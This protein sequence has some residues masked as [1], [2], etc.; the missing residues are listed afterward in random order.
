MEYIYALGSIGGL[1]AIA[2][3]GH[4]LYCLFVPA[5]ATHARFEHRL[6]QRQ[7]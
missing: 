2:L 6:K 3:S 7:D 1:L 5:D 4:Y